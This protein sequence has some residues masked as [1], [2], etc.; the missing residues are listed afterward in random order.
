MT[1]LSPKPSSSNDSNGNGSYA[2]NLQLDGRTPATNS[3]SFRQVE[4]SQD[5]KAFKQAQSVD[6]VLPDNGTRHPRHKKGLGWIST[7]LRVKAMLVAL[8]IGT[9]PVLGIGTFAYISTSQ[10]LEKDTFADLQINSQDLSDKLTA[11]IGERYK[12]IQVYAQLPIFT[13][14]NVAKS[15]T[16]EQKNVLLDEYAKSSGI[17]DSIIVA[18][19][20]GNILYKSDSQTL[21]NTFN[22]TWFQGVLKTDRPYVS[23]PQIAP[24]TGIFSLFVSAPIKDSATG[25]TIAIIRA[26]YPVSAFQEVFGITA[27]RAQDFFTFDSKNQIFASS[28]E[29]SIG[30]TIDKVF[31]LMTAQIKKVGRKDTFIF[32]QNEVTRI[33]SLE[34]FSPNEQLKKQYGLNWSVIIA[35]NRNIALA[36]QSQL[37]LTVLLGT[38]VTLLGVGAIAA[39][40]ANRATRPL[41]DAA[42]AVDKIGQGELDTRLKV[43]GQDELAVL[44]SNINQMASQLG[45][46]VQEQA[47]LAKVTGTRTFNLQD[48]NELFSKVLEDARYILKTDRVLIYR[49]NP[50]GSG[51]V[52]AESVGRGWPQALNEKIEES[53]SP[54]QLRDL[55]ADGR[56]FSIKNVLDADLY[57]AQRRFMERLQVMASL[58]VPILQEGKPYGLL[59]VHHCGIP[60]DWQASEINFLKQL[61]AQLGLSLDRVVLLEETEQL[62]EEQRQ[63][64]EGLQKRALELLMEVDPISKGDLT[65]RAKVTADEIGTIADS[66]NS[67]VA[68]LRKIVLQV[69]EAASQVAQT[70]STNEASVQALSVEAL[71][72]AEEIA[73][74]LN[75]AQEMAES[76]RVIAAN[77]EQADAAVKEAAQTVQEGDMAMNRT[78]DGILSI[79][80]TVAETAKKVKHLGESSQ[81]ISTVVNLISTFAAQTNLL[82]LNA[83]IEAARAGEEGRGFAVVADEVRALARQSAEA[84]SEIEK[85]VAG[86]QAETNEV[87]AAMEAGTEQVVTGTKLVDETRQSLN[88][89]TAASSKINQLVEA[90]TQATVVQSQASEAVTQTMTNVAQIAD[91]TSKEASVVSSSFEELLTVAQA[92]QEDVRRFKVS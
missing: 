62:A 81:K 78:V 27:D 59:M 13:D 21:N 71:R 22:L 16:V 36:T 91:K 74:A 48:L 84:T 64:K 45:T 34:V 9:L 37:L 23:E 85:L 14:A 79:R 70:T 18:D 8:A 69:Q 54:E 17:Y 3:S 32:G 73:Q 49:F 47:L 25:K 55:Y 35:T 76:V 61:A 7:S 60:H 15:L 66:Y 80:E 41:L 12:D 77:A 75:K 10:G 92:L 43:Q 89:I 1:Q 46:F 88:K 58:E 19:L 31:P 57:P 42:S 87:V 63:L 2:Q 51:D 72:Q 50:D 83:S 6:L 68:N 20:K 11:F 28:A 65:I 56:V 24:A 30:Q 86:I 67:T 26:R 33:K 4:Y 44:G 38:G 40:I 5:Q 53:Y 82:A 90:I 39:F 29:K 52:A